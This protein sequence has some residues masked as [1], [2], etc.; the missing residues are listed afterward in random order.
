MA[1]GAIERD[2]LNGYV[3]VEG[4]DDPEGPAQRAGPGGPEDP[5]PVVDAYALGGEVLVWSH[6]DA[7][8]L[9]F[10]RGVVGA[11]AGVPP[12]AARKGAAA[13]ASSVQGRLP[14][15]LTPEE[16]RLCAERGWARLRDDAGAAP[17]PSP[18][19]AA[20]FREARAAE[21]ARQAA[22]SARQKEENAAYYRAEE[23][24]AKRERTGPGPGAGEGR[25]G[26]FTRVAVACE[27]TCPDWRGPADAPLAGRAVAPSGVRWAV[28]S[29]LRDRGYALTPGTKFGGD[30]LVYPGE[31]SLCHASFVAVAVAG[32]VRKAALLCAWD[33]PAP[34]GPKA[35]AGPGAA[36]APE[37]APE[38]PS[39]EL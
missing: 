15:R 16:A 6:E 20:A 22:E 12:Q 10:R 11:L 4:I 37:A 8:V 13:G 35:P 28:Y 21:W 31:P 24:S 29:D 5:I 19:E 14:L 38:E 32:A 23:P 2:L 33:P 36:A 25:G 34:T 39:G 17:A 30:F 18:A 7:G 27:R 3:I 26:T 9:R 1:A